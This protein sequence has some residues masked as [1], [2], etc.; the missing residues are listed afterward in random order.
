MLKKLLKQNLSIPQL[1]GYSFTALVGMSIIFTAFSFSMDIRPLFSSS[2]GLFKNEYMIVTKKV[3]LLSAINSQ[4]TVFTDTEIQ[5]IESQDFTKSLSY[6]TP[7]QYSVFAYIESSGKIPSFSTEMF[8]ESVPD[9]LLD[10]AGDDWQWNETDK[11][12]P[13][14]I[15]RD[16][17]AL[18][19]FGFAGSRGLPQ[20]SENIVKTV[21]FKVLIQNQSKR[22][23]FTGRI[24]GFSD[25]LNTILVPQDFMDWA[26][27]NFGNNKPAKKSKL[28][29]TVKN[30]ADPQ[31]AEFFSSKNYDVKE[32]K[33][34]QGKL[35]YFLK[36]IIII[37]SVVG[38]LILLPAM[39]LMFL[40]INL[41][42][43]KNRKTLGNLILL[44]FSR[45]ELAKPYNI[46]VFILNI[47]IGIISFAIAIVSREI[48]MSELK[49]L[50]IE[51]NNID[52]NTIFFVLLF[53][54]FVTFADIFW[55][56]KKINKI[57]PPEKG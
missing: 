5:E 6:F 37:I 39:G 30:P 31:T 28:I 33:G 25:Y 53:I 55:I 41:L 32:N 45:K 16:Y 47:S 21:N 15:P 11:F 23:T 4:S 29:I 52:I 10:G 20:I 38:L 22:E 8:F 54:L 34:E 12:I 7:C 18:Y 40:S 49:I 48:Y 50:N 27:K 42:I 44:G 3:S 57:A 19:N 24:A 51:N 36:L 46:L 26:N 35:S 1:L 9:H 56:Y 2:T 14:I 43:Y 13:V 17:L